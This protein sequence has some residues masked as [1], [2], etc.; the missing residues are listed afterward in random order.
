MCHRVTYV[1][2]TKI[3]CSGYM[4]NVST[5]KELKKVQVVSLATS[6]ISE[7]CQISAIVSA[8]EAPISHLI[9]VSR[10][11]FTGSFERKS[12]RNR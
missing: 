12:N 8:N 9:L 10:R 6:D 7:Q 3:F 1:G 5:V 4:I 11:I 2:S